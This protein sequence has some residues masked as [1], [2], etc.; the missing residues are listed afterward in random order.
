MI[1]QHQDN[2]QTDCAAQ[3][4]SAEIDPSCSAETTRSGA[5]EDSWV[6]YR[7]NGL[8]WPIYFKGVARAAAHNAVICELPVL[9][10]GSA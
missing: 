3:P 2:A 6:S 5:G 7:C 4:F 10:S 9:F 1:Y 8:N